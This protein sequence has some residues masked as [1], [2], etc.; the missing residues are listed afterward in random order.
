MR[1]ERGANLEKKT[2]IVAETEALAASPDW[3]KAAARIQE[4][5]AEWE[6]TGPV[7]RDAA[8]DLAHRFRTACNQF[9]S[10]RREDLTTR[11]KFWADNLARKEAL[12]ARAEALAESMEWDAAS[13]EMKRLQADWKTVGPVRRNRSEDIWHRFRAAAD[14]F[15]ERYHNRHQITL[16]SKLA[17]RETLVVG[18]ESFASAEHDAGDAPA[19]LGSR[20]QELRAGWMRGVP[21]PAAEMRPLA[22][23]WQA[24]LARVLERWP[25]AFAGTDLDPAAVQ[26]R[27]A[28]LVARIEALVADVRDRAADDV[29]QTEQLAARL[30][31]ALAS[32][33]MGGRAASESHW[34]TAVDTVKDAQ[35][36]WLRLPPAAGRD[37]EALDRRFRDACRRVMDQARRETADS[38]RSRPMDRPTA[39]VV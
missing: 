14:R 12:C 24:A 34:R 30:R 28:K 6:Q 21:V 17:E 2:A 31:S 22:D 37:A 33:A 36:A 27:M 9:F 38:R 16:Q 23:R 19:G 26:E 5:Q 10:R 13:A 18:L 7:A 15:F 1:E 4:L 20:V 11:K 35:A 25:A 39:A 3:V 8:R 29:S 32:N